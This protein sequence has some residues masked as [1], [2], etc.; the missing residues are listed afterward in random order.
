MTREGAIRA[1]RD[2]WEHIARENRAREGTDA[3]VFTEE[4]YAGSRPEA[5]GWANLSALCGYA[6]ANGDSPAVDCAH[7][8][9]S[10]SDANAQ[11]QPCCMTPMQDGEYDCFA[12]AVEHGDT[13]YAA[14]AA[15]WMAQAPEK[16]G[17]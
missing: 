16:E 11:G 12:Y 4:D 15:Q 5:K 1:H 13:A 3:P 14:K 8:P 7:C 9:L 10:W 2:M 6:A 17:P